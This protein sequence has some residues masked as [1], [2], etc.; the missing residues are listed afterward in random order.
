MLLGTHATILVGPTVPLPAGPVLLES[1]EEIEVSE[2]EGERS[3]FQMIL[4]VGRDR[5]AL[6][7]YPQLSDPRLQPGSRVIITV[8]VG[9]SPHVLVDGLITHTQLNPS[10]EPGD[11]TL[12]LTGVDVSIAMDLEEKAVEHPGQ[13]EAAIVTKLIAF[14]AAY[15]M[16]PFVIPP[17]SFDVPLPT[18]R[19]PV[20][21][22]TD[23]AYINDLA[24]RFDY[25]FTVTPGPL[26]GMNRAYWGPPQRI[27]APQPALSVAMGPETNVDSITFQEDSTSATEV[28]GVVQ[29]RLT[30]QAV[31]VQSVPKSLRPPL[32][33]FPSRLNPQLSSKKLYQADGAKS[34][35]QAQAAAQSDADATTDTVS[36]EGELD[37]GRYRGLLRASG[38]VGLRGVG[39]RYDGLYA[40]KKVTTKISAG[41]IKQSFSLA[42][43]GVGSTVPVVL[44]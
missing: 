40:V 9:A 44:P 10:A 37:S 38:L 12:V 35:S 11:T 29:D 8:T 32:A 41:S 26:P 42:R 25:V 23:F 28:A 39:Y 6:I 30:N 27:S 31:P 36:A 19:I 22:G 24:A 16:V 43:E 21:Q 1:V 7:D 5:T 34:A 33:A 17:L 14:Y 15:G 18:D 3:G 2:T 13:P 20:Q 4:R